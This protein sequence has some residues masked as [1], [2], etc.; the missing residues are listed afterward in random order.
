MFAI[1]KLITAFLIPPGIFVSIFLILAFLNRRSKKQAILLLS[2][3]I[4]VWASSIEPTAHLLMKGV[5]MPLKPEVALNGDVIVVLGGG[6]KEGVSDLTGQGA[7]TSEAM[8]RLVYAYRLWKRSNLPIIVS[9]GE[10]FRGKGVE[11]LVLKR[12]LQDMGVPE[13]QIMVEQKSRDTYENLRLVKEICDV[14]GYKKPIVVTSAYHMKRTVII[15]KKFAMDILPFPCGH[16]TWEGRRFIWYEYLP[17]GGAMKDINL[18]L[19][20]LLGILFYLFPNW[21]K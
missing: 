16:K 5:E 2:V 17:S 8:V 12:F 6:L 20:E 4:L 15:S 7:L 13:E 1:K 19:K 21:S 9:G 10:V 18:A 14:K 11:A 3:S